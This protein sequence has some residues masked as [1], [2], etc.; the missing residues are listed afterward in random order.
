M[1]SISDFI[2]NFS[3]QD[4]ARP[5]RFTAQIS[6]PQKLGVRGNTLVCETAELP[7]ITY[8]TT[9]QKFGSNPIEKYPYQVQFNDINL[10]FIVK[11]NMEIKQIMDSWMNLISSSTNYNFN[12]KTG[13]GGYAGEIIV[14][15]YS[16]LDKPTYQVILREAYPISVNQLDLDWS[17]DG[18]HKL[19][20]VFAYTYWE[21]NTGTVDGEFQ[22]SSATA[23]KE[24]FPQIQQNVYI[25][26][27]SFSGSMQGNLSGATPEQIETLRRMMSGQ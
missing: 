22:T 27:T 24:V 19:T 9:E 2:S 17:S 20:V 7:S 6:Y 8:A 26:N 3:Q 1:P 14:T 25:E 4:L 23:T 12:Y 13:D 21:Q 11:E 18:Y 15:Q 16:L 5:N 10:T